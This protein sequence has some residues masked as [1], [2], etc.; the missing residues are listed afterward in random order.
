MNTLVAGLIGDKGF[1]EWV[2]ETLLPE[3]AA[4]EKSNVI[5]PDLTMGQVI[6]GVADDDEISVMEMTRLI[7][8]PQ[9]EN[10]ASNLTPF[11]DKLFQWMA[12]LH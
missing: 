5:Q 1:R 8:G 6:A 9:K 4:E 7:K 3:L 2:Y 10:K 11:L 12:E